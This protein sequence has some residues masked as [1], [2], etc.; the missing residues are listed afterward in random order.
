M[1]N[2][3]CL[4]GSAANTPESKIQSL[5]T[6]LNAGLQLLDK[7]LSEHGVKV[8]PVSTPDRGCD[9]STKEGCPTPIRSTVADQIATAGQYV[10]RLTSRVQ[11]MTSALE[12]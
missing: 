11:E 6:D 12:V 7:S 10:T 3:A 9:A 2:Q 4:A 5:L 1:N 8:A